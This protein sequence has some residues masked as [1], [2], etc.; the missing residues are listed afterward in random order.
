ME[1]LICLYPFKVTKGNVKNEFTTLKE[2]RELC[3]GLND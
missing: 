1:D 3:N 2:Y